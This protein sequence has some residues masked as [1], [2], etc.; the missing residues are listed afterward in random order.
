MGD[1]LYINGD[2][3]TIP[4]YVDGYF[5]IKNI[6]FINKSVGGQG[7]LT[8]IQKTKNDLEELKQQNIFPKVCISLSE[9]GRDFID[10]FK[11]VHPSGQDLDVYLKTVL[12]KEIDMLGKI[13]DGYDSY[14]TVGWTSNPLSNKSIIDFIDFNYN[15][16]EAWTVSNGI[17]NWLADRR[18]IFKFSK[19]S[20]IN[21]VEK[22]QQWESRLLDN[23]FIDNTLHIEPTKMEPVKLWID[24]V[25][26]H[27]KM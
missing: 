4:E 13:L 8:I 10:E 2:S 17:Y 15:G 20:F 26:D 1:I 6:N 12:L 11:L 21:T 23:Q 27:F 16:I 7:N 9:V 25:L 18:E 24:H 5:K 14:V 3:W 22:K 19:E